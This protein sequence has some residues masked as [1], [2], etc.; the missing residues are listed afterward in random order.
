MLT[1]HGRLLGYAVEFT[2][3]RKSRG[4]LRSTCVQ[5]FECA[6]AKPKRARTGIRGLSMQ[7]R[8][9]SVN[10]FHP[11]FA[12]RI[13]NTWMAF[14]SWPARQG[15]QRS[16][17]RM[18]QF[19]SWAFARSPGDRSF[20]WAPPISLRLVCALRMK[21]LS[22]VYYHTRKSL[23]SFTPSTSLLHAVSILGPA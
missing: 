5:S 19:L 6:A 16:L 20:A 18:R 9:R 23:V 13:C 12:S 1:L 11:P 10:L 21:R 14:A 2:K 8:S 3:T 22:D 7:H 15:Q 4:S 17:R